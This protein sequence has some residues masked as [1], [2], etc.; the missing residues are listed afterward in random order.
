MFETVLLTSGLQGVHWCTLV[1]TKNYF[2]GHETLRIHEIHLG[3][4]E[5][6]KLH[7]KTKFCYY[8]Y[9]VKRHSSILKLI[10]DL[11]FNL[12]FNWSFYSHVLFWY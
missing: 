4:H 6:F 3:V 1:N 5:I 7:K 8:I 11:V 2:R 10:L 12:A 9:L